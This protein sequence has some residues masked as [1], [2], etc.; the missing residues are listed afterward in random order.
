MPY[1]VGGDLFVF[2][3]DE[4]D[5]HIDLYRPKIGV[6]TNIELDHRPIPQLIELFTKFV[7]N[8]E[9]VIV[10]NHRYIEYLPLGDI[11]GK[12]F[13]FGL[14][15][16]DLSPQEYCLGKEG[17]YFKISGIPY[18]IPILGLHNLMN[19]LAAIATLKIL[20]FKDKEISRNF[21]DFLGIKGRLELLGKKRGINIY[22]DYAHN[23]NKIH[24]TITSLKPYFKRL[25]IIFQPHGYGPIR[26]L[27]PKLID[28]FYKDLREEDVLFIEKIYYA[29][30]KVERDVSSMDLVMSLKRMGKR[31]FYSPYRENTLSLVIK[32][33]RWGDAIIVMGA[34]DRTLEGFAKK[35][36]KAL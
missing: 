1:W 19:A 21:A 11:K 31:V 4:S 26:L 30:G 28:L 18:R 36:A 25:L 7:G 24:A 13:S 3:A 12:V 14:D 9:R 6:I 2:E 10:L 34:R 20:G 17:I 5:G 15:G 33:A 23:P 35:I 32:M 16:K 27:G 22:N 8:V 29:G